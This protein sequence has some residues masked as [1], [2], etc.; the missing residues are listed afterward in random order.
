MSDADFQRAAE[1]VKTLPSKPSENDL[2]KLYGLFK[3]ATVGDNNVN[4]PGMLD[5][6]GK[7]KWDAWNKNKGKSQDD[8]KREYVDFVEKL[9]SK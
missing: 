8:A 5:I 7:H 4:K 1:E 6:K 3:Q 2:L 9:K